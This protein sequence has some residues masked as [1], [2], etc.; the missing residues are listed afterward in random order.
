MSIENTKTQVTAWLR[1]FGQRAV[2][3]VEKSLYGNTVCMLL[4]F[5]PWKFSTAI[6]SQECW[7][8]WVTA[9]RELA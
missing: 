9:K 3:R 8:F 2:G 7:S 6:I 4:A 1:K 5:V